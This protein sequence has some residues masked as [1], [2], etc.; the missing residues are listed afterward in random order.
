MTTWR[1]NWPSVRHLSASCSSAQR[2]WRLRRAGRHALGPGSRSIGIAVAH[3]YADRH[4]RAI[5]VVDVRA[6][7]DP[8]LHLAGVWDLRVLPRGMDRSSGDQTL[9]GRPAR[10]QRSVWR[11]SVRP[12][13]RGSPVPDDR[14]GADRQFHAR[15]VG[16]RAAGRRIQGTADRADRRGR[17]RRTDRDQR[18]R[19]PGRRHNRGPR[20]LDPPPSGLPTTP[21]PSLPTIGHGSSRSSPRWTSTRRMQSTRC[22]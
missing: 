19:R 11:R 15:R 4:S 7:A 9:Y 3:A 12:G 22:R 21:P 20:L 10:L 2:F 5:P 16:R 8:D 14:V 6:A 18:L 13:S 17:G 1:M